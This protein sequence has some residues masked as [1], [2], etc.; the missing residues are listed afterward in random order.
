[1][2]DL[3]ILS[4]FSLS[5]ILILGIRRDIENDI[6]RLARSHSLPLSIQVLAA[7]CFFAAENFL[8]VT[9]ELH[10]KRKA[11]ISRIVRD[12]SISLVKRVQNILNY[13]TMRL[14]STI[15]CLISKDYVGFQMFQT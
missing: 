3:V 15:P 5:C 7:L 13:P 11:S 9:A 2:D 4:K 6:T 8:P 10:G 14:Q 12:M 1:M